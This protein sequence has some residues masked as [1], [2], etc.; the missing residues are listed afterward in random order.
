[1]ARPRKNRISLPPH[2]NAVRSRGKDY[3]YFHPFR[4]TKTAAQAIRIPGEPLN[5]D[6]MPNPAWWDV[7]RRLTGEVKP[8]ARSGSFD[9][10]VEAY[11]RSPEWSELASSTQKEWQRHLRY[12]MAS[13]GS[14]SVEGIEPKHVLALRDTQAK[15]PANANNLLRTLSSLLAWGVPRGWRRDNPCREIRK[16]K[17]GDGY[18]PWPWE[19][20]E[21]FRT[22]ARLDLWHAAALA[23][24]S[25]Q[26]LADVLSMKW[27][28]IDK[29][30]IAVRQR[31]TGKC[32]RIP[33][34]VR[35]TS[36]L[37]E[38]PRDSVFLLTSTRRRPWTINGFK[39]S[40]AD[41]LDRPIMSQLRDR[42]L[43]FH[44]LRKSAVVTL[45]EAGATDAQVCA[46]TGQSREM[47]AHYSL[48]V[49]QEKLAA[50]AILKWEAAD[51]RART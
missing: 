3:Y 13:W 33:I 39:A 47:V 22:H 30:L 21:Y 19:T 36:V 10:L 4:G 5:I 17:I 24:Y 35:L 51:A 1:V 42:R 32:L 7:Y 44:G 26:R 49:N 16:L 34:H 20:I 11:Q 27:S 50:D 41:E 29:G 40:W 37:D 15:T 25:G 43:V 28:D 31:K 38:L 6:G 12:I 8:E 45:L 48:R 14:L 9:A 18:S 23:L 46:V 2:V